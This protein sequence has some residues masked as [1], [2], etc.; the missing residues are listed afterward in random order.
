M[1]KF[2]NYDT[3]GASAASQI[4]NL[5]RMV[6]ERDAEIEKLRAQLA[7]GEVGAKALADAKEEIS[8]LHDE[9]AIW[10]SVFPDIAPEEVQPDRSSL[11]EEIERLRSARTELVTALHDIA[12]HF[13]NALYAFQDDTEARKKAEGDIAHAMKI[14][15]R[16]N[17]NGLVVE[18]EEAE[19]EITRL[20]G[21]ASWIIESYDS[22]EWP[23]QKDIVAGAREAL[24]NK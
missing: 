22:D 9:L 7:L 13:E 18:P 16:H 2:Y 14:A 6:Q 17:R 10:K 15:A 20:R 19:P 4:I 1:N 21:F 24:N 5:E 23:A 12:S 3:R 11:L 8:R